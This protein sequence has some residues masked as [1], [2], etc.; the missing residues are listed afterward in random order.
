[1]GLGRDAIVGW[2]G[3]EEFQRKMSWVAKVNWAKM[4]S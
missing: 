1:V 4:K 2:A 3:T